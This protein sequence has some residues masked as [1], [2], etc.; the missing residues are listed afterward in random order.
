M[1]TSNYFCHFVEHDTRRCYILKEN[2]KYYYYEC[3]IT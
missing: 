3:K 1:A 2:N